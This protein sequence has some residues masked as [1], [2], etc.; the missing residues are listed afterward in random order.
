M[1]LNDKGYFSIILMAVADAD[2]KFSYVDIGAY[3]KDCDSSVF[4]QSTLFTSVTRN[5]LQIPTPCPL[6]PTRT[7]YYPFVLVADE[8]F[9][10]SEFVIRP[11]AGHNLT[12]KKRVFNYRVTRARRFVECAFGILCNKWRIFHRAL[13]VSKTLAKDIVKAWIILHNVVRIKNAQRLEMYV[14]KKKFQTLPKALCLRPTKTAT[15]LRADY[16]MAEGALPWKM[17]KI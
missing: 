8:A 6:S 15:T 1:N 7:E 16:F 11:F 17:N 2:Y 10:L 9:G 13:N 5:R 3:G 14:S 12:D 4:Q